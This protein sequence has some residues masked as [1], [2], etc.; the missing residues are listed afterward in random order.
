MQL[1]MGMTKPKIYSGFP[2]FNR[3]RVK[4]LLIVAVIFF[5]FLPTLMNYSGVDFSSLALSQEHLLTS[6]HKN[7]NDNAHRYLSGEFAHTIFEWTAFC[8]ALFIAI[9]AFAQYRINRELVLPVIAIAFFCS[10]LIDCFHIL[11][12]DR[13]VE[14]V[15]HN[16]N[17]IPFTWALCRTYAAV[18][19]LVGAVIILSR[20]SDRLTELNF[21]LLIGVCFS[22]IAFALIQ[23]CATTDNLPR[24]VY[25]NAFISRPFDIIPLVLYVVLGIFIYPKIYARS[26]CIFTYALVLSVL[27]EVA[28][29]M[30]MAFGSRELFDNHF[31]IAHVLKVLAYLIPLTGLILDYTKTYQQEKSSSRKLAIAKMELAEY[32]E[33]LENKVKSRTFELKEKQNQLVQSEKMASVGQLAAGVAHEINNPVGFIMGNIE[34]LKEYRENIQYVLKCYSVLETQIEKT[35][36]ASLI[37][38][39][40]KVREI[41]KQKEMDYIVD[42]MEPLINDSLQGSKRIQK[43]V[44]DLKSFSRVDDGEPKEVNLNQDVIET[45]LRLVWNELKYKCTIHKSLGKIPPYICHPNELSQVVMNILVNAAD[46]ISEKGHITLTSFMEHNNINIHITDTGEGIDE[47]NM[48]KLFDPFFTTKEIGKG[49]GLGLSISQGLVEKHKGE[50]TV[51]GQPGEGTTFKIVLPL[52]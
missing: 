24:T 11:V 50:I 14:S 39:L 13:L 19:M 28:V 21:I 4:Y 40:D 32:T 9:L 48:R 27:P 43:I 44:Q 6:D 41:K 12:A 23:W 7:I 30:H 20:E 2:L 51:S 47:N 15:N 35:G 5:C 1:E 42:D 10:G 3:M 38:L 46:A 33:E 8:L 45:A 52:F 37:A 26:P 25:E 17:F 22:G 36:D 31:N 29:E 16:D 18:V 34:V 49:T